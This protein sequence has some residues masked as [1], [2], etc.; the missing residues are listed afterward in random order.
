MT[1][2]EFPPW[3]SVISP[4]LFVA[5]CFALALPAQGQASQPAASTAPANLPTFEVVSVKLSKPGCDDMVVTSNPARFLAYCTT[6]LGLLH[7]AYPLSPGVSIPGL[8][9]WGNWTHFD[10][11]AKADGETSQALQTVPDQ[12][13]QRQAHLM[14]QAV[15]RD[16]FKLRVHSETREGPVYNLAVARKGF[17][18]TQAPVSK[19]PL[20]LPALA[21][22]SSFAVRPLAALRSAFRPLQAAR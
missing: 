10:V 21:T 7:I 17:K 18:L 12:E 11:D 15:L 20:V 22:I 8:P 3:R 5:T 2:R 13:R 6:L 9:D 1:R 19:R 14:L 16:R 4:A